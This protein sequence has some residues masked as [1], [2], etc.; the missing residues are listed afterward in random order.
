M[1]LLAYDLHADGTA[2]FRRTL[3]DYAPQDGPDG[4]VCDAEGNIYAAVRDATRPGIRVYAP[5][6]TERAHI[7]TPELPTNVAFGR[8]AAATTLY[9]TYGDATTGGRGVLA[10]ITVGKKGYQLPPVR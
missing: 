1:A 10:R 9:V 7:P 8:G 4:L 5:D 6:G 3:V 2:S